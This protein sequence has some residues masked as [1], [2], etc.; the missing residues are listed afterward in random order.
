M[1]TD[2]VP[3]PEL[4]RRM[5]ARL[6][7]LD[8]AERRRAAAA[9]TERWLAQ[10]EADADGI[11]VCLS[12]GDEIDT[13][14]LIERLAAGG[15]ELFVTRADPRDRQLHVHRWPCELVTLGFGLRQPPRGAPE[16]A[17]GEIASRVGAALVLGLAFD[18]RGFRL[19]HGSGYF[20]RFLAR[21]PIPSLGFAFDLQLVD[22]IADEPHDVPMHGV[23]TDSRVVR[24]SVA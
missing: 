14:A 19:G 18:R 4:R 17:P 15:R 20:D 5:I 8:P 6:A 21:H 13:A 3:K 11:L 12:F 2:T 16:L 10:P 9:A 23:V 1:N 22:R 24:R 7:A